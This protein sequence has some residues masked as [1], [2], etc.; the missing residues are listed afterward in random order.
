MTTLHAD[1]SRLSSTDRGLVLFIAS[2]GGFLVTFLSSGINVALPLI[3]EE[4]HVSAVTLSWVSASY[5][6]VAAAML[7][8]MGWVADMFGRKRMFIW[9]MVIFSAFSL[10]SAFAP[11]APILLVLRALHGIGLALGSVTSVALVSLAY[12]AEVRGRALGICTSTVYFGLTVGPVLGG[13]IVHNLGWRSM[14]LIVGGLALVN[15]ALPLWKLGHVE[16]RESHTTR[17]DYVGSLAYGISLTA[18]LIGFSTLP[19]VTGEVLIPAGIVGLALFLLWESRVADPLL[20][21][22]LLRHSRVFAFSNVATL[23]GYAANSAMLFLMSLYLQYNRGLNAQKAGLVLVTGT[24]VQV[25]IAPMAGR[26][27]D[28]LP[29]RYVASA[30]MAVSVLGLLGLSFVGENSPYWYVITMLCVL[31]AG[32][33]LFATPNTTAIMGSVEP[34]WVGVA[35]AT[36]GTMRQAGMSMSM[37]LATLVLALEVG[38]HEIVPADYPRLL[39]SIRLSFLIF[40]ALC[41]VGVGASLVGPGKRRSAAN[42]QEV[43]A[44]LPVKQ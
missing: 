19:G 7:L 12:P 44:D 40:T 3:E 23:V 33:A 17:F 9:S 14:F 27:A 8:P 11:S 16:W 30:G 21:V 34:R 20:N 18:V 1:P 22:G 15:V 38:R 6:L 26:L 31:G 5:I 37:G 32:I 13:F 2:F 36:I 29:A 42:T 28:R 43:P 25:L 35:A 4:F 41:V 24:F 39:T 10:G